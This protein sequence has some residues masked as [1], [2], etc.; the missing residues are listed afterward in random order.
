MWWREFCQFVVVKQLDADRRLDQGLHAA[1]EMVVA[2]AKAL[3]NGAVDKETVMLG[4]AGDDV[5]NRGLSVDY[6]F[7]GSGSDTLNVS[8]TLSGVTV[9]N[10][11]TA[12][13]AVAT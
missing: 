2:L 13:A 7:M 9:L 12:G 11:F 8:K 10:D 6:V 1:E 5:F 4:E 3:S